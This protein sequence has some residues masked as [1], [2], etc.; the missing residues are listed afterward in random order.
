MTGKE[1]QLLVGSNVRYYREKAGLTQKELAERAG[2][3]RSYLG[4]LERGG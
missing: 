2:L 4:S 3:N 1:L